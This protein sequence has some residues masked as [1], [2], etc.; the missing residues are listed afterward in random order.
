MILLNTIFAS[1]ITINILVIVGMGIILTVA[2]FIVNRQLAITTS[3]N[4]MLKAI[5]HYVEHHE[6]NNE[7]EQPDA[8]LTELGKNYKRA[9]ESTLSAMSFYTPDGTLI[10]VNPAMRKLCNFDDK[11][12]TYYLNVN[13]FDTPH[14]EK[15]FERDRTEEFHVCQH[16]YQPEIGIDQFIEA[17]IRPVFD[18]EGNRAFYMFAARD[19]TDERKT[20]LEQ[21]HRDKELQDANSTILKYESELHY[22]LE[23]SKMF[24]WHTI[25][26]EGII[27]FSQ[28]YCWWLSK[29]CSVLPFSPGL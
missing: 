14:L 6:I 13:M 25:D 7:E 27:H 5:T 18:N 8:Q 3:K 15:D 24:V 28:W 10:D 12:D 1:F 19:I 2:F 4:R 20:Y 16:M 21:Q 26:K 22:L 23:S 29:S 17:K 9:F 11:G